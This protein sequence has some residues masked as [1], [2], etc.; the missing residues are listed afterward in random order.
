MRLLIGT[1]DKTQHLLDS[2]DPKGFLL[3]DDGPIADA[4]LER[5]PNAREFNTTASFNPL[6]NIDYKRARD[7]A[8]LLYSI[9]PQGEN[10]LTVRNGRR[11]L[12]R[13]L[14]KKPSR[15][16]RLPQPSTDP[17]IEAVGMIDEVLVSPILRNV[18]CRTPNFFFPKN[19]VA[20]INRA[21]LG[22]FDALV[23]ATLLIGQFKG[24]VIVPDGGFY[25]RDFYTSLIRQNRLVVGLNY[26]A[27][28]PEKL[29]QAVLSIPSKIISKTTREDA[30]RL[31]FYVNPT[32]NPNNLMSD[33]VFTV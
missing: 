26:L 28:L 12:V 31:I 10:T 25:L 32:G 27:E 29:Q 6:R 8:S 16:D 9:S 2:A 17:E 21:E 15:L 20:R 4:F 14:L 3:I 22:D 7:F 33:E 1:A 19:I 24:Q 11:A 23:L 5:F 13:L 30:E 18:F